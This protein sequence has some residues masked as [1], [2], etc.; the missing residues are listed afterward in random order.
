[1]KNEELRMKNFGGTIAA[2]LVG[3]L[4]FTAGAECTFENP[5]VTLA[6]DEA[7]RIS[8]LREK[9]SG[10]ELVAAASPMVAVTLKDGRELL[11]VSFAADGGLLR[12]G[13]DGGRATIAVEP[14]EGGWTFT[15]RELTVKDAAKLQFARVMPSSRKWLGLYVNGMSD[16]KSAVV[17]RAYEVTTEMYANGSMGLKSYASR[18][19][20]TYHED[21][22]GLRLVGE[23]PERGFVGLRGGLAAGPRDRM[24]RMLRG[25]TLAA[26]IPHTLYGGAWSLGSDGVRRSYLF[27][28]LAASAA[29]DW[30][31]LARRA[32]FGTIH[33]HMWWQW[34]GH[35]FPRKEFF[36]GGFDEMKSVVD[37]VHAAGMTAGIHTLSGSIDPE[38]DP[39]VRPVPRK[40]LLSVVSYTLAKD[41]GTDDAEL[42]VNELPSDHH[43]LV[44]TYFSSGN[45]LRI[46]DE[47]IDYTGVSRE[48]PYRFTGLKRGA[49]GTRPASHP[50]GAR[51]DYLR[52]RYLA[53]YPDPDTPLVH[54]LAFCISNAYTRGGFDQ[55]YLDGSEGSGTRY[56]TDATRRTLFSAVDQSR[57][58]VLVEAS[59]QGPHNWWFH[60]RF[61]ARDIP[62]LG[63]KRFHDRHIRDVR[64]NGMM[65]NFLSPQL[66]WWSPR[67]PA[68]GMRGHFVDEMEY[69]I[70]KNAG[71]DAPAAVLG[72]DVTKG[73]LHWGQQRMMT[74]CGW[75]ERPRMAG[76]FRPEVR[77]ALRRERAEFRLRQGPDGVWRIRPTEELTHRVA[78]AAS[79]S[80]RFRRGEKSPAAVRVA[81]LHTPAD[82]DYETAETIVRGADL[83]K[84]AATERTVRS[85]PFAHPYRDLHGKPGIGLKVKGD[86]SGALLNV[87]LCGAREYGQSLSEHYIR[88]D[89]TGWRYFSF[90]ERERD[91]RL[92]DDH[93]WPYDTTDRV[94]GTLLDL[95]HLAS[96]D[97]W[98]NDIPSGGKAEVEISDLRILDE[99]PLPLAHGVLTV[100]GVRHALPFAL[101]AGDTAELEDGFWTHYDSFGEPLE[102]TAAEPVELAAG[103]NELSF[104]GGRAEVTLFP[105]GAESP[106]F[107]PELTAAMR[108]AMD[109]E[110]CAPA[111]Y[112]PAKGF[113]SVPPVAIRPNETAALRIR[114]SGKLGNRRATL[115]NASGERREVELPCTTEPLSGTWTLTLDDPSAEAKLD[116]V[117]LY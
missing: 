102:R 106:A 66:G 8:S 2:A 65:A 116:L 16:E 82:A 57:G 110:A 67:A 91:S 32:G 35:Y 76:V 3:F 58:P 59:C 101:A 103:C 85:F 83:G 92:A 73:P 114:F 112:A 105:L 5:D 48:K 84:F 64:E 88:L 111:F 10:R 33:F 27:A 87:Q 77:A 104:E 86:G 55:I 30:I 19:G 34:L 23:M 60:S 47:L 40:D 11:P 79:G 36:P 17:L 39:W 6:F 75:Y 43:D 109:Y 31:D 97:F 115:K 38:F 9:A 21:D 7:G 117:K 18:S 96:V 24:P 80:W 25:M 20:V 94:C 70:G 4:A 53:F 41:L 74:V 81:A 90:L 100:N 29:D 13:F 54:E 45:T 46:G 89:F 72:A 52:Q 78:D 22:L 42:V 1:M 50:S 51:C 98:L 37:K 99:R 56:A 61:G 68:D 44:Y 93:D 95:G 26:G 69:F 107:V 71:W 49:F 14:F 62:Y 15:V 63:A 113:K 108:K 28:D 12:Y